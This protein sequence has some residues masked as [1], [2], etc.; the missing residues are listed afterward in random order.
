MCLMSVS[1]RV[2]Y[3]TT[4]CVYSVCVCVLGRYQ[5]I[6]F[7]ELATVI[8]WTDKSKILRMGKSGNSQAGVNATILR[9]NFFLGNR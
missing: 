2:L 3:R 4:E 5:E 6:Y 9:Q 1:V 8:V 7:K